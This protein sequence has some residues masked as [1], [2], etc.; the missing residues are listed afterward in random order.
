MVSCKND[1]LKPYEDAAGSW[2]SEVSKSVGQIGDPRY[3]GVEGDELV[4]WD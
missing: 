1:I 3:A 4:R 2:A